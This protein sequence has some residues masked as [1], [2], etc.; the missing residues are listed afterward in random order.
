MFTEI[1]SVEV[2]QK[3][4]VWA[5][6][7]LCIKQPYIISSSIN[8]LQNGIRTECTVSFK[9]TGPIIVHMVTAHQA[10]FLR[11]CKGKYKLH[12]NIHSKSVL[13]WLFIFPLNV[14]HATLQKYY[15]Q[16]LHLTDAVTI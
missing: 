3:L 4:A 8:S 2:I 16:T 14:N 10:P 12:K 11:L 13:F 6:T 15:K 9:N 7:V 1:S 5:V